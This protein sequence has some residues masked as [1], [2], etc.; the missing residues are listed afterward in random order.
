MYSPPRISQSRAEVLMGRRGPWYTSCAPSLRTGAGR[1]QSTIRNSSAFDGAP[2]SG[3]AL[4]AWLGAL[5]GA[6]P[7]PAAS[8]IAI[9]AASLPL[10][11]AILSRSRMPNPCLR[12]PRRRPEAPGIG[13]AWGAPGAPHLITPSSQ[14]RDDGGPEVL[15]ATHVVEIG[16][17]HDRRRLEPAAGDDFGRDDA[18]TATEIVSLV[19]MGRQRRLRRGIERAREAEIA[20]AGRPGIDVEIRRHGDDAGGLSEA[21]GEE[22]GE[23]AAAAVSDEGETIEGARHRVSRE[24]RRHAGDHAI[25][26]ALARPEGGRTPRVVA[27]AV[28]AGAA[29]IEGRA[30]VEAHQ[31]QDERVSRRRIGG[32][33]PRVPRRPIT[34]EVHVEH[35]RPAPRALEHDVPKR[36]AGDDGALQAGVRDLVP[37][38]PR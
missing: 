9:T 34:I 13:E 2:T 35:A 20:V 23:D 28:V 11:P 25:R 7:H 6:L 3:L 8:R 26:V 16:D 33:A 5:G 24:R 1:R 36:I 29:E 31:V 22:H 21:G 10:I 12:A 30:V 18:V 27:Q 15:P 37:P 38:S 17:E 14:V 32:R 19:E 4:P